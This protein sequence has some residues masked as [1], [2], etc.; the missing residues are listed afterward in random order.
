M[1]GAGVPGVPVISYP[2]GSMAN[3]EIIS[4]NQSDMNLRWQTV[5][6]NNDGYDARVYDNPAGNNVFSQSVSGAGVT[7]VVANSGIGLSGMVYSWWVRSNN[8][9]CSNE[10]SNWSNVG[11]F[12]RE[13]HPCTIAC[14]QTTDC[15]GTTCPV[16]P[17]LQTCSPPTVEYIETPQTTGTIWTR[18]TGVGSQVT[19]TYFPTWNVYNG[20]GGSQDDIVWYDG[21][22]QGGGTW[23]TNINIASHQPLVGGTVAVHAYRKGCALPDPMN[24]SNYCGQA[25]FNITPKTCSVTV[26]GPS[27]NGTSITVTGNAHINPGSDTVRV[28]IEKPDMTAIVGGVTYDYGGVLGIN[29]P[30]NGSNYYSIDN[31]FKTSTNSTTVSST[32]V[33]HA[34][35]GTYNVH[36]DVPNDL[37]GNTVRCSGNP[38]CTMN[39]GALA[40]AGWKDCSATDH[41]TFTI[42]GPPTFDNTIPG[43][44]LILEN[45]LG[46]VVPIEDMMGLGVSGNQTCDVL[47]RDGS[48]VMNR[49]MKLAVTVSDPD[50]GNTID[51]VYVRLMNVGSEQMRTSVSNIGGVRVYVVS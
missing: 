30:N 47:F 36:C 34:A 28:W 7:G 19:N 24:A 5:G 46:T 12:C 20:G 6:G 4:C 11:Y 45:G 37:N 13:C 31:A 15:G 41:A 23:Q 16:D 14:G 27:G 39:G 21:V 17:S 26:N 44:N 18:M 2:Q 25:L 40:C 38:N 10:Y 42:N 29:A 48:G 22:N 1:S 35:P 49:K 43:E 9:T 3:P 33:V 8:S 50:G 32:F 51:A